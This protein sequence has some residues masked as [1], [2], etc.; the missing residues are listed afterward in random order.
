MG[1]VSISIIDHYYQFEFHCTMGP[2][3]DSVQLTY[4]WLNAM[5]YGRYNYG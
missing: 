5:V 2:P 1:L 3:F 4:K